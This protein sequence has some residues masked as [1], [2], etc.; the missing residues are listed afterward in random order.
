[1]CFNVALSSTSPYGDSRRIFAQG[2]QNQLWCLVVESWDHCAP[3]PGR[4]TEEILA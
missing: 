2:N 4:I 1:M 3:T